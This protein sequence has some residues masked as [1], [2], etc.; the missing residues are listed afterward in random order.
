MTP[1]PSPQLQ[2]WLEYEKIVE[3]YCRMLS[4][5]FLNQFF[6]KKPTLYVGG[7]VFLCLKI[8]PNIMSGIVGFEAPFIPVLRLLNQGFK[9]SFFF[10][11]ARVVFPSLKASIVLA[12]KRL[13][14][15]FIHIVWSDF[16]ASFFPVS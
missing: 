4:K 3:G 14:L 13:F 15:W 1:P 5:E 10:R 12:T 8:L 16:K 2:C 11:F 6:T 9:V 7:G